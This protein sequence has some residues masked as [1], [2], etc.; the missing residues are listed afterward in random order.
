MKPGDLV[1]TALPQADGQ[2]KPRPAVVLALLPPFSD[3]V[4]C[5]VTTQL[6]HAV[7]GFDEFIGPQD[8]DFRQSALKAASIIRLGYLTVLMPEDVI[9]RIGSVSPTRLKRLLGRLGG[10]FTQLAA[11]MQ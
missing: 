4:A 7:P 1:L 9:C 6:R 10:H 5:G 8:D 3:A 2:V 11:R